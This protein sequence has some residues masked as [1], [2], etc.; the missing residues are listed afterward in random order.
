MAGVLGLGEVEWHSYH[1]NMGRQRVGLEIGKPLEKPQPE[2]KPANKSLE[3]EENTRND[4]NSQ[5]PLN[6]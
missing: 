1:M 3:E 2:Q 4:D 6:N 5:D